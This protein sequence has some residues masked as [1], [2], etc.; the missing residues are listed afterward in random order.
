[1]QRSISYRNL[2]E[3]Y[4]KETQKNLDKS[5]V[6][7]G[8]TPP[9]LNKD[10]YYYIKSSSTSSIFLDFTIEDPQLAEM[11]KCLARALNFN[12]KKSQKKGKPKGSISI[13]FNEEYYALDNKINLKESPTVEDIQNFLSDVY[14][15]LHL[16]AE[17]A[18]MALAYIDRLISHTDIHLHATNW[19][20]ITLGSIIIASKVWEDLAVWNA[21]F[22]N[23]FPC[24]NL[25][26]LSKLERQYLN[27]IKYMV[28]LKPCVYTKYFLELKALSDKTNFPA[29]PPPKSKLKS[30]EMKSKNLEED[31]QITMPKRSKSD[32]GLKYIPIKKE[33]GKF[34]YET[35][36]N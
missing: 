12:I 24:T 9:R 23:L 10:L 20:R 22:L 30:L 11:I 5:E 18:V 34:R 15:A 36:T 31:L 14:N 28:T 8:A 21:D 33:K 7:Q 6:L 35:Q 3:S 26:D 1:M 27:A 19:R 4:F 16:A 2:G 13:I 32:D 29:K 25:E 17:T